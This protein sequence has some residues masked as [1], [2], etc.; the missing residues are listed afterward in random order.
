[1][2]EA[3][4]VTISVADGVADVRLNRP[5][6]RNALDPAMFAGL[7]DASERLAKDPSV[8]VV[9][10]SGEGKSFCA[11]LDMASFQAM[12]SEE[13][14]SAAT[15]ATLAE[16]TEDRPANHGQQAAYGWTTL[17]VPVIAAV[18]GHALGGGLQIALGCDL[19]IVSPDAQLSVMEIR[20]G[21]VPDMTGTQML[22]RLLPLDVAKEL[23]WTG[24]IVSGEEAVA[25]GLA[26]ALSDDPRASAFELAQRL[27]KNNPD[28]LRAG[29]RL[30]NQA[31]T[32]SDARQFLDE[33]TE[34]GA[35]IGS[36]N[37]REAV[38]A[39]FDGRDPVFADPS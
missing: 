39:E 4:R 32:V 13:P 33:S 29:K 15:G 14:R 26:T 18:H 37:Q 35:L 1:M 28:A 16:R 23:V 22:R 3:E 21:L 12:A 34:M 36:A 31:G 6:K 27:A 11:G 25:L 5:E 2:A 38:R 7:V 9:V 10:L 24:R 17:P 20:W 30:L 8:R 19:R